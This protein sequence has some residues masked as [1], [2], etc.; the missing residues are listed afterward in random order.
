MKIK[1]ILKTKPFVK[2]FNFNS[3]EFFRVPSG[4]HA[5]THTHAA[6]SIHCEFAVAATQRTEKLFN[7][8]ASIAVAVEFDRSRSANRTAILHDTG[9]RTFRVRLHAY[10]WDYVATTATTK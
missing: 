4:T 10:E 1:L 7:V 9:Q 5:H 8:F 2:L 3:A 6:N